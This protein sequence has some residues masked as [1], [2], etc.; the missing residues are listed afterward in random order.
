MNWTRALPLVL[1]CVPLTALADVSPGGGCK[2]D[3]ASV[4]MAP[5]VVPV[6]VALVAL[7]RR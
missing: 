7:W 4:S 2:C 3:V 1:L 5:G 6:A